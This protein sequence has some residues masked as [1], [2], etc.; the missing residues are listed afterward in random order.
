MPATAYAPDSSP[1]TI[2]LPIGIGAA[3]Y[4]HVLAYDKSRISAPP[5][6]TTSPEVQ[7]RSTSRAPPTTR[8]E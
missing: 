6:A 1:A 7:A 3:I 4:N 8:N 2:A 5:N